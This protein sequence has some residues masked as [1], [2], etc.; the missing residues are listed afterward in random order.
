MI[1]KTIPSQWQ[2]DRLFVSDTTLNEVE[3]LQVINDLVPETRSWMQGDENA[4]SSMRLAL[5]KGALP[6][7]PE[8]SLEYFRLQSVRL[9]ST[10]S[11]IGFLAVYHGFPQ[12]DVFWINAITFHPDYQGLGYGPELFLA[13]SE[14]VHELGS[15]TCIRSYVSLNNWPSLK[16]C[17][18]VGMNKMLEI[19]RDPVHS[20]QAH[21]LLE[22]LIR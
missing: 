10:N 22:K 12:E 4:E 6:P 11:L 7:I 16:L 2:T 1:K 21:V 20:D 5:E 9:S 13:L 18:K 19:A 8:R 14:V 17:V 3:A 15:Y